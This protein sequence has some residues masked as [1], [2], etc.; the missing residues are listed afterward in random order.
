MILLF[1]DRQTALNFL[2]DVP[3][4]READRPMRGCDS[5]PY[6]GLANLQRAGAMHAEHVRAW[7]ELFRFPHDGFSL[8]AGE[9][10]VRL[11]FEPGNRPA[12]VVVADASFEDHGRAGIGRGEPGRKCG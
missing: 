9:I 4:G 3:A 2:D 10:V 11:V 1:P 12:E 5:D 6:G 8:D 7:I